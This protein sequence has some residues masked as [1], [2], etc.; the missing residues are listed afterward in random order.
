MK[1]SSGPE[2][3]RNQTRA[4][5]E[6][7]ISLPRGTPLPHPSPGGSLQNSFSACLPGPRASCEMYE[8]RTTTEISLGT[9][10]GPRK[11]HRHR[12]TMCEAIAVR[13]SMTKE[14]P[15]RWGSGAEANTLQ[16]TPSCPRQAM[17]REE[18]RRGTGLREARTG[19]EGQTAAYLRLS[20][21]LPISNTPHLRD[22]RDSGSEDS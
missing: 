10:A 14:R 22:S 9:Q 16:H 18:G 17:E 2:C 3:A 21:R 15:S 13:S 12:E 20:C 4:S 5:Q 19:K 6:S 1:H 7:T 11:G 8:T